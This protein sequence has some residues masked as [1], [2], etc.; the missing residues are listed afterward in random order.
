MKIAEFV[1]ETGILFRIAA[2]DAQGAVAELASALASV[3]GVP[4]ARLRSLLLERESL[5]STGIGHEI[6]VPHAK[7]D[8]PRTVGVLGLSEQGIDFGAPD[9]RRVRIFVAF[10]SPPQGATHL[11][12]LA[13]VAQELS[14]EGFRGKL[15]SAA[16]ARGVYCLLSSR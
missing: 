16:D 10:V 15:L 14:D 11:K 12:A 9:G 7:M 2:S 1:P 6:A 4:P 3:G 5:G 8:V 13:A